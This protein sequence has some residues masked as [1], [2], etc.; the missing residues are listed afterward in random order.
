MGGKGAAPSLTLGR[1][2]G[3]EAGSTRETLEEQPIGYPAL[4]Q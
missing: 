1:A 4:P 3:W 2:T